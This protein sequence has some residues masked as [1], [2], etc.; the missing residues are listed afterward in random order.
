[1]LTLELR[2][3]LSI[4]A[5]R[6]TC[7]DDSWNQWAENWLNNRNRSEKAV[8]AALDGSIKSTASYFASEAA[9]LFDKTCEL[10]LHAEPKH[11][12]VS[13]SF[14]VAQAVAESL[15]H[16]GFNAA[17]IAEVVEQEINALCRDGEWPC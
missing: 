13:P 11:W 5:A 7:I 16:S 2:V 9:C 10:H 17:Q 6:H 1:M 12:A 15:L 14:F 4:W 8:A 3:M